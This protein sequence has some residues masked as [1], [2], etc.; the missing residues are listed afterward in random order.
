MN[1]TIY[2]FCGPTQVVF[3]ASNGFCPNRKQS[4]CPGTSIVWGKLM[5]HS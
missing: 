3:N 4:F 1:L 5:A 2:S